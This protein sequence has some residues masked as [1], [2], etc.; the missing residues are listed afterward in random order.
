MIQKLKSRLQLLLST[1]SSRR[2]QWPVVPALTSRH[3]ENCQMLTDREVILEKLP[4]GGVC[5]ELGIWKCGFSRKIMKTVQ[6][7][8]LHL[9]DIDPESIRIARETFR[10]E[11]GEGRVE[12]HHNDS[13]TTL[14]SM[15]D[16]S[17]DWIYIDGDHSYQGVKRDLEAAHRKLKP[18]GLISLNDYIY[19]GS[20]DLA[21]YGVIEAVNEF[22][23]TYNYELIHFALQGRMY[24]DVTIRRIT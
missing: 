5:A 18:E 9:I 19:F 24:N 6:P 15:N 20:S 21:K 1:K 8:K 11:I 14:L 22:C 17:F 3:L 12:V 10:N 4:R 2:R 7:D 13:S 16:N 23:L